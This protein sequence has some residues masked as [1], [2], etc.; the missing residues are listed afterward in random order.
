LS[1]EGCTLKTEQC[2]VITK[3][4]QGNR[5]A[6]ITQV[7]DNEKRNEMWKQKGNIQFQ[8]K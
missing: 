1:E 4:K 7:V 6:F 8:L 5:E 2:D 3:I